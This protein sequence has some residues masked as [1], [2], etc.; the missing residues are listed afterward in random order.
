VEDTTLLEQRDISTSAIDEPF[1]VSEGNI[2][3]KLWQ[4]KA[5]APDK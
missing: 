4:I 5:S 3:K 1:Q 2:N